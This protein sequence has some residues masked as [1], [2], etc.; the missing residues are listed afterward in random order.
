MAASRSSQ[1]SGVT[2]VFP[3]IRSVCFFLLIFLL[4]CA[5]VKSLQDEPEVTYKTEKQRATAEKMKT[6]LQRIKEE[7]NNIDESKN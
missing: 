4:S 2:R 6:N 1:L 3:K 5:Q 7:L